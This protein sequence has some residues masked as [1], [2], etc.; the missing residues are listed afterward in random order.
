MNNLTATD[1]V[2]KTLRLQR[3]DRSRRFE[4]LLQTVEKS[5]GRSLAGTFLAA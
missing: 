3:R 4:R 5:K 2:Q 1:V